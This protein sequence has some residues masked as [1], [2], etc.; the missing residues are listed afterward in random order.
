MAEH[1]IVHLTEKILVT[2]FL[3]VSV[4]EMCYSNRFYEMMIKQY[5]FSV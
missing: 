3:S 1:I 4:H 5:L 2:F